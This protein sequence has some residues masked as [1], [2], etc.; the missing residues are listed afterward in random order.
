MSPVN[1][2]KGPCSPVKFKKC[3]VDFRGLRPLQ[4]TGAFIQGCHTLIQC[5]WAYRASGSLQGSQRGVEGRA[6]I[7]C[8]RGGGTCPSLPKHY[9]MYTVNHN[10][11]LSVTVSDISKHFFEFEILVKTSNTQLTSLIIFLTP[12]HNSIYSRKT[13]INFKF[14]L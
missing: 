2:K 12:R 3:P 9:Q 10:D 13:Y 6:T 11:F 1:F 5:T 14:H 7:L 8:N 4:C